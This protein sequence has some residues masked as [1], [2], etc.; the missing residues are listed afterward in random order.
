MM[1]LRVTSLHSVFI[2]F[3]LDLQY[4]ALIEVYS[5]YFLDHLLTRV[6]IVWFILC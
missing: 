6:Y 5:V 3:L 1:T 2:C 4:T